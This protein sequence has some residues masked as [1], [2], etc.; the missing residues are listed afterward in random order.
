MVAVAINLSSSRI[1]FAL[2]FSKVCQYFGS[3]ARNSCFHDFARRECIV[4]RYRYCLREIK[5]ASVQQESQQWLKC[6]PI[7]NKLTWAVFIIVYHTQMVIEAAEQNWITCAV[8]DCAIIATCAR[9]CMCVFMFQCVW[10]CTSAMDYRTAL[11]SI[12]T[13]ASSHRA[14]GERLKMFTTGVYNSAPSAPAAQ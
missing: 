3:A 14:E 11:I 10:E 9:A 12:Q 4:S 7:Q 6:I 13:A 5:K 2:V 8:L 1:L